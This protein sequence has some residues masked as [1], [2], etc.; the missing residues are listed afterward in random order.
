MDSC[1]YFAYYFTKRILGWNLYVIVVCKYL[2]ILANA[3]DYTERARAEAGYG[4]LLGLL[5][6]LILLVFIV[7]M[8]TRAEVVRV[9]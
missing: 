5:V 2:C 3:L 9:N 7:M 4:Q 1:K 6:L 8:T